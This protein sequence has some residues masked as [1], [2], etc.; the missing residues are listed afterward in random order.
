MRL[1]RLPHLKT[2]VGLS[3]IALA[4]VSLYINLQHSGN[5]EHGEHS[6]HQDQTVVTP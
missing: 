2:V 1:T 6:S 3:I 5:M 4:L